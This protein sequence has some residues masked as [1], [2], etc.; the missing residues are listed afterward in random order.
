MGRGGQYCHGE[1]CGIAARRNGRVLDKEHRL[2][3][4]IMSWKESMRQ[5]ANDP[6]ISL[7]NALIADDDDQV[8]RA[9]MWALISIASSLINMSK[10][11]DEEQ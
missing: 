2:E 4:D 7:E 5:V 11:L 6:E 9:T 10:E 8:N 1:R 3:E